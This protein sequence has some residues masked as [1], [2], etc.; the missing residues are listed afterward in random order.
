V[1]LYNPIAI[2]LVKTTI[3]WH[4]IECQTL[5]R[6]LKPAAQALMGNR[7]NGTLTWFISKLKQREWKEYMSVIHFD[8]ETH[9]LL[10]LIS[11]NETT[12]IT[13]SRLKDMWSIAFENNGLLRK[14]TAGDVA[15]LEDF[16]KKLFKGQKELFQLVS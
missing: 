1:I 12:V 2:W 13:A 3:P 4:E 9:E 11:W 7:K 16:F 8:H 6:L 14:H 15:L 5:L 10:T